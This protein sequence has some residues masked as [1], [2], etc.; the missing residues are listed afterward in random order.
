MS[1]VFTKEMLEVIN[2]LTTQK[3]YAIF[4]GFATEIHTGISSSPDVDVYYSSKN[5]IKSVCKIFTKNGW[6]ITRHFKGKKNYLFMTLMKNNTTF[7][8]W[9]SDTIR[10]ISIP[11]ME[12]VIFRNRKLYTICKEELFLEKMIG[13][14]L[15]GRKKYKQERDKKA[16]NILRKKINDKKLKKLLEKIP[17]K[18]FTDD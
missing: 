4:A 2:F 15:D 10:S 7:D 11:N 17:A 5:K 3:D 1:M 14:S 8:L 18:F 6:K 16:V 9:T 12:K 13:A